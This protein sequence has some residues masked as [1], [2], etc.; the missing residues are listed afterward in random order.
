[1]NNL[2][3]HQVK[4]IHKIL[5]ILELYIRPANKNII[6]KF[7]SLRQENQFLEFWRSKNDMSRTSGITINVKLI[8]YLNQIKDIS[9]G[10]AILLS[11][12]IY[13]N[14]NEHSKDIEL[15]ISQTKRCGEILK[16][17]SKKQMMERRFL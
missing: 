6:A 15:L 9:V 2:L 13:G 17:I 10:E 8:E 11:S 4:A 16:Q 1:M 12:I 3:S 14:N 5:Q 7:F